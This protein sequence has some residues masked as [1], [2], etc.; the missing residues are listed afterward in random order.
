MSKKEAEK[1]ENKKSKLEEIIEELGLGPDED[2]LNVYFVMT[3]Y[4]ELTEEQKK[5]ILRDQARSRE[6]EK[7][8]RKKKG[9]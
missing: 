8:A 7:K 5:Q 1:N 2:V 6:A 4:P 3:S 9:M